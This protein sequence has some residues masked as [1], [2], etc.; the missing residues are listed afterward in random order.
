MYRRALIRLGLTFAATATLLA[1]G[2]CADTLSAPMP[3]PRL[4]G[5]WAPMSAELGG[6]FYDIAN[7]HGAWLTI[8]EDNHY[9]FAIDRGLLLP[10][11]GIK[12]PYAMDI[13]GQQGPNKGRTILA[14][15]G[16]DNEVFTVCYQLARDGLRPTAFES[17]EGT[18]ILLVRYKRVETPR[19]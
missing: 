17:P 6:K 10:N 12:P 3:A 11:P 7:F 14:I 8:S 19:G 13:Q 5:N 18:Q 4:A 1:A 2:G 16:M 15:Y 9:E